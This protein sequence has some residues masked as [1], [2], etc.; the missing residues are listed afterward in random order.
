MTEAAVTASIAGRSTFRFRPGCAIIFICRRQKV[1][2]KI[3]DVKTNGNRRGPR[4]TYLNL[5]LVML[6]GGL[7]HGANWTFVV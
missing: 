2:R 7:W 5:A 3:C 1:E 6:F 4:R